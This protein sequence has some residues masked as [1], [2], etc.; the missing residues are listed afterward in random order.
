MT[1]Q[2]T[3]IRINNEEH[4][5]KVQEILFSLGYYWKHFGQLYL[6]QDSP[7][8]FTTDKGHIMLSNN[9]S[10]FL[11]ED[12]EEYK[13]VQILAPVNTSTDEGYESDDQAYFDEDYIYENIDRG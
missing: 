8:L 2:K 10:T 1:F 6:H 3:K 11:D 9:E 4:S 12:W 5:E 7:F 13:I